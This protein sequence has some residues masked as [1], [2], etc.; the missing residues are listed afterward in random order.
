M[1]DRIKLIRHTLGLTQQKFADRLGIKGNAIS[2]YESG[3][4]APIDAVISLICR[5]FSVN[6][7]WLRTGDGDMFDQK[8]EGVVDRLYS[9]LHAS[10]LEA[11]II[12]AYFRLDPKIRESFMSR[13]LV[14]LQSE[15][16]APAADKDIH[17]PAVSPDIAS[18]L[19]DLKRQNQ[20]LAAKVAAMEEEEIAS[21]LWDGSYPS[22]F[23]L[24]GGYKPAE[25]GKK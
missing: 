24:S 20:E 6:E 25:K 23:G 22:R 15:P 18:E 1:K 11:K 12:R 8:R 4:N 19:A 7:T 3:R 17:V 10:D 21:G 14:E 2:Q 16:V 5:E 9:E 13:L